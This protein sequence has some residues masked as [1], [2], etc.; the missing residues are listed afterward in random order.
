MPDDTRPPNDTAKQESAL[1]ERVRADRDFQK[2]V[3]DTIKPY[4]KVMVENFNRASELIGAAHG[5]TDRSQAQDVLRAAVVLNHA[6]LEDLLRTLASQLLPEAGEEALNDIPLAGSGSA[7]HPQKFQLGRLAQH[8][9]K[10]VDTVIRESIA[11]HLDR[12]TYND[13]NQISQLLKTLGFNV[14]EHNRYFPS[15]QQMIERRHQIVHRADK[16]KAADSNAYE[17]QPLEP[18]QVSRWVKATTNFMQSL[19]PTL[20]IK[21]MTSREDVGKKPNEKFDK[22]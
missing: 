16:A 15:I 7:V 2:R 18:Q 4:V 8:K 10:T 1:A 5:L 21:Q 14:A 22:P 11:Q 17:L 9:G 3:S 6:Y 12:A 19:M 13:T 20:V